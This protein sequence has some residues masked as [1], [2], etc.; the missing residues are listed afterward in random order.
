MAGRYREHLRPKASAQGQETAGIEDGGIA[1]EQDKHSTG[2][3]GSSDRMQSDREGAGQK[4]AG[5]D[6]ATAREHDRRQ[7]RKMKTTPIR[8]H[9]TP[10]HL[11]S[12]MT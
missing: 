6:N 8:Q 12:Y 10:S 4:T 1:R 11:I 3:K 7:H 5:G 9:K 2:A